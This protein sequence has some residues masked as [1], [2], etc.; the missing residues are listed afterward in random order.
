ML[1]WPELNAGPGPPQIAGP[2]YSELTIVPQF[3]TAFSHRV[4]GYP[5][6]NPS[7]VDHIWHI[8]I[9]KIS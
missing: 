8:K 6:N 2:K 5:G 7:A 1:N 9:N 3:G 4:D